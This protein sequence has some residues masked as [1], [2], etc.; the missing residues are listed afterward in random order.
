MATKAK[1]MELAAQGKGCLGKAADDEPL[2]ILR[3]KDK[4]S[5]TL[6][7]LWADL[8]ALHGCGKEKVREARN[9]AERME[10]YQQRPDVPAKFPD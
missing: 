9:L 7:R 10:D 8:A 6:V 4:L 1:E 5:P 3:G 2:F